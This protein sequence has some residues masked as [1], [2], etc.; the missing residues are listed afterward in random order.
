MRT[1]TYNKAIELLKAGNIEEV[2]Q[3]LESE[4]NYVTCIRLHKDDIKS[5]G[6]NPTDLT[7]YDMEC[8]A[9]DIGE[10]C[11]DSFWIV[12]NDFVI[13]KMEEL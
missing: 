13:D 11:L 12:I 9:D 4:K 2:I 5:R 1:K 10:A 8:L 3:I 6:Y 7:D